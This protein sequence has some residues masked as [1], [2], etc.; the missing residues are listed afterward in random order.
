MLLAYNTDSM[1]HLSFTE[2]L[3]ECVKL[4]VK[5]LEIATGGWSKS[6][7]MNIKELLSNED[8]LN[9]FKKEL[10]DRN[11]QIIALNC[12]GNH[13]ANNE[14]GKKDMETVHNTFALAK[15]LGVKKIVMMSGL[16]CGNATD[17]TPVWVTTSW[18]P[19]TQD[20]LAYQWNEVAIPEWKKL[21]SL[22]TECGIE[23]I[24]IENHPYQLVYSVE[25]LLKLRTAVG[26]MIGMNLDPSHMFWMNCCPITAARALKGAIYHVHGKDSRMEKVY[27]DTNG[28]L[29]TK[30]IDAFAQRSWNFVAVGCGHD[31]QWWKEFFSVVKMSGYDEYISLE[32]EDLTMSIEA[33]I[34]TSINVLKQ[35]ICK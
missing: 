28:V 31:I 11:L 19:E 3:D 14:L 24:A 23:R 10:S 29:D 7:H 35:T 27:C 33:G 25:T 2:M 6:P 5:Y 21:C 9:A 13:L 32:M 8:S 34:A 20:I 26:D 4:G 15:K 22:A 1:G 18:P 17:S 16:P 30:T 12:S